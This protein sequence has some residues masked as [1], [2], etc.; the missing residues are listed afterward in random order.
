MRS[1]RKR[2]LRHPNSL[3]QVLSELSFSD[4][5]DDALSDDMLGQDERERLANMTELEREMEVALKE[6]RLQQKRQR[7]Q[8]LRKEKKREKEAKEL[9]EG[10]STPSEKK[11]QDAKRAALQELAEKKRRQTGKRA[12][13]RKYDEDNED[14]GRDGGD[15][16]DGEYSEQE[17]AYVAPY[18]E[19]YDQDDDMDRFEEDTE[20]DPEPASYQEA[21]TIQVRRHKMEDWFDKPFFKNAVNGVVVRLAVGSKQVRFFE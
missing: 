9:A 6:E 1:L 8:L 13:K 2:S 11:S 21:K 12:S 20:A 5:D 16:D 18:E 3:R 10:K 7:A 19:A 15:S 4:D 14:N 17:D